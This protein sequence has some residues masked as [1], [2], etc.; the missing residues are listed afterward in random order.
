MVK[1]FLA[2]AFL[3]GY[4]AGTASAD[5]IIY[6]ATSNGVLYSII[7]T[8]GTTT[9]IGNMGTTMFDIADYDGKLYGIDGNSNLYSINTSTAAVTDIGSTGDLLNALTFNSAGVLYAAGQNLSKLYTI[10]LTTG[11]ATAVSGETNTTN[12]NTAGDLEF[13]GNTLYITTNGTTTSNLETVNLTTGALTMLGNTGYNDVYG[14][15][16]SGGVLYGFT[17]AGTTYD[18]IRLNL[19]TGAGTLVHT[20]TPT[21]FYGTTDDPYNLPEPGTFVLLAA[22]LGAVLALPLRRRF[23]RFERA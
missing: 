19:T 14:L 18:V 6:G 16:Y 9:R 12:Y 4:L 3:A 13:I 5:N 17:D 2:L 11:A 8:T 22:G 10:N 21:G 1:K 7:P 23:R 15:A 20:Y